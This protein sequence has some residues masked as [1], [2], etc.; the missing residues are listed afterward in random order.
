MDYG[1]EELKISSEIALSL[2]ALLIIQFSFRLWSE[3]FEMQY[4]FA[5]KNLS[6]DF[7]DS[8]KKRTVVK[9]EFT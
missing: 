3:S 5:N 7:L 1:G 9:K 6:E 8:R 4:R 2:F